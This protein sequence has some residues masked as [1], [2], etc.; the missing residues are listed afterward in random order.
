MAKDI[1]QTTATTPPPEKMDT[2]IG[3]KM[4]LRGPK[5]DGYTPSRYAPTRSLPQE[6][7]ETRFEHKQFRSILDALEDAKSRLTPQETEAQRSARER[8]EK[9]KR[10]ITSVADGISAIGSLI[11]AS[12]GG[13]NT[14]DPSRSLLAQTNAQ[15]EADDKQ[16]AAND[17][18]HLD[19][20]QKIAQ[21]NLAMTAADRKRLSDKYEM[22]LSQAKAQREKS[23]QMLEM[24]RAQGEV[25]KNKREAELH[26][27]AMREQLGKAV[28]AETKA[29]Y[30][31][32]QEEADINRKNAAAGASNA[33]AVA[34]FASANRSNMGA[35]GEAADAR[36]TNAKADRQEAENEG[37]F[38]PSTRNVHT[39]GRPNAKSRM[40]VTTVTPS[41]ITPR[42]QP[43]QTTPK[44]TAPAKQA[45]AQ[46]TPPKQTAPAHKQAPKQAP[47]KQK[48]GASGKIS[49][50][51]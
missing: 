32:K 26:P 35:A 30:A 15:I 18:A 11:A 42:Q 47:P 31:G 39:E 29:Q 3:D 21:T 34:S 12:R 48:K 16:R 2:S 28:T 20:A 45:P 40:V 5:I 14:Y 37:R 38:I 27:L 46:K 36:L 9:S 25:D 6:S 33:S 7:D 13:V 22:A 17:A 19:Y 49:I 43:K 24:L 23:T 50:H 51:N 8:R 41:R 10:Y 1:K 4:T 44:Q